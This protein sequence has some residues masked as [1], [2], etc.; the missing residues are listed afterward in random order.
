MFPQLAVTF[1]ECVSLR[2]NSKPSKGI[3]S[4]QTDVSGSHYFLPTLFAFIKQNWLTWF[5]SLCYSAWSVA[6]HFGKVLCWEDVSQFHLKCIFC[7]TWC[8]W[9]AYVGMYWIPMGNKNPMN[10]HRDMGEKNKKS[11]TEICSC[12]LCQLSQY[13]YRVFLSCPFLFPSPVNSGGQ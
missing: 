12:L 11:S 4:L 10:A 7:S 5:A 9:K 2:Q 13:S 8:G 3:L 6:K 1:L